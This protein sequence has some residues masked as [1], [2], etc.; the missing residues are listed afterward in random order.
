LLL[1]IL[2]NHFILISSLNIDIEI[3]CCL[4]FEM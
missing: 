4:F 3:W 2:L 1:F